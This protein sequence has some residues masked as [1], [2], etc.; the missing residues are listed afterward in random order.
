M[1]LL[2][3][4]ISHPQSYVQQRF[5]DVCNHLL[6]QPKITE[7]RHPVL[8]GGLLWVVNAICKYYSRHLEGF[9]KA[10]YE[11]LHIYAF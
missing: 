4:F 5:E 6:L 2:L 8:S 1:F 9:Y 7:F 11:T 10:L 3:N